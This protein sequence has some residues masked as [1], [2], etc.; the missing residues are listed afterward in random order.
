MTGT[1]TV[2]ESSTASTVQTTLESAGAT[3]L[4]AALNVALPWTALPVINIFV[5]QIIQWAVTLL[6]TDAFYAG[7]ALWTSVQTGIDISNF[8]KAQASGNQ[9][10]IDAAGDGLIQEQSQ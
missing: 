4:E 6:T 2:G 9:S 5:D 8:Q 10:A 7:F 1:V 3:A